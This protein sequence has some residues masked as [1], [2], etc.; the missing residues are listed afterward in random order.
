MSLRLGFHYH[1]PMMQ[2]DSGALRTPGYLGRFIDSIAL[3]CEELLCFMHTPNA[4]QLPQMDYTLQA[5][6]IRFVS[7]GRHRS[8]P[9]RM[10]NSRHYV[11]II[12]EYSVNLDA[13]LIRGPSPLLPSLAQAA[14][15]KPVALLL[16]GDYLA[17]ID[18]LPQPRWRKEAIR[19]W[20]WW[21]H[22]RQ[23]AVA[24][25][26][27]TFVNSHE[28]Y[29]KYAP[30]VPYLIE[31]RTTTLSQQD[32]YER[33]DTC[34]DQ[35]VRLLYTG[36]MDRAKGLFEIQAALALLRDQ[37]VDVVL[38][39]VGWPQKGDTIV[40]ELQ[41]DA[42]RRGLTDY[43]IYHGFK[44]VGPELFAYYRQA[45]IYIIASQS[46]E[47]FPRTIWEA[48]AHSVP[49]L[50]TRVG[51]IPFYLAHKENVWLSENVR[52][53]AI[54]DGVCALIQDSSLRQKLIANAR[55]LASDNTLE[56]RAHE[57]VTGIIGYIE[58]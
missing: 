28:L 39:I 46:T 1:L 27:L 58:L 19:A 16:V 34:L 41:A 55:A 44:S 9:M 20:S 6:N 53:Q 50:S 52:A 11:Q 31:T 14:G 43:I 37:G 10:L 4:H 23:L 18:D 36:R 57:L 51:S 56:K 3:Q 38:D 42:E 33:D 54:A 29:E 15:D 40:E 21:N 32:F 2:T 45:D 13:L 25:R 8:V 5:P 47:G 17:G 7:L 48:M 24:R 35:P 26:S 12:R 30:Q 22:R 49:F